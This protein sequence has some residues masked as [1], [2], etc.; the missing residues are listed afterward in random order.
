[1]PNEPI[2]VTFGWENYP[3][4][5]ELRTVAGVLRSAP[6]PP[7]CTQVVESFV[8]KIDAA[9][10]QAERVDRGKGGR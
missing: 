2:Y 6:C 5:E 10:E 3:T 9:V 7:E 1:M 4:T 8:A